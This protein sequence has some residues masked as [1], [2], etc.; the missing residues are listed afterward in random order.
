[1]DGKLKMLT[2]SIVLQC[3]LVPLDASL[4]EMYTGSG[5][6]GVFDNIEG[7]VVFLVNLTP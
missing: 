2:L 6:Y 4:S 1:M 5:S 7:C 3:F